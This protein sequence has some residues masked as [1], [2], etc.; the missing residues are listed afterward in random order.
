MASIVN[1]ALAKING[2]Y[3]TITHWSIVIMLQWLVSFHVGY[4]GVCFM[5]SYK[6][7]L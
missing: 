3:D 2:Y 1:G 4:G 5:K 6:Y 7:H